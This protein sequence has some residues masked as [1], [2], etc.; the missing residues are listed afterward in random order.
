MVY[1]IVN[2]SVVVDKGSYN[3]ALAGRALRKHP[4]QNRSQ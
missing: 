4:L 2:G 3:G 1:V